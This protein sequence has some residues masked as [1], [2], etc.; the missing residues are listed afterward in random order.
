MGSPVWYCRLLRA[1]SQSLVNVTP[2][3]QKYGASQAHAPSRLV[4]FGFQINYTQHL[5]AV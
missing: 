5:K 2:G 3:S 4:I 1:G